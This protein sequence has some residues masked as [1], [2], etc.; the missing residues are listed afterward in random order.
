MYENPSADEFD[1]PPAPSAPEI[2]GPTFSRFVMAMVIL[3]SYPLVH[4][5]Q[6]FRGPGWT[7]GLAVLA[8][9]AVSV[10]HYVLHRKRADQFEG[11]DPYTPPTRLTR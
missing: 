6:S 10:L 4:W 1:P 2:G 3:A 8:T 5:L 11:T 9:C 7:T